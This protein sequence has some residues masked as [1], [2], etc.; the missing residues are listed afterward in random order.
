MWR[1]KETSATL[2][3]KETVDGTWFTETTDT[4]VLH[5]ERV[6]LLL[7]R[8]QSAR[9]E[10]NFKTVHCGC[11]LSS[12]MPLL[13]LSTM[14]LCEKGPDTVERMTSEYPFQKLYPKLRSWF[15]ASKR[16]LTQSSSSRLS[17]CNHSCED[18]NMFII[19]FFNILAIIWYPYDEGMRPMIPGLRGHMGR[20]W[21]GNTDLTQSAVL[22]LSWYAW[23][24][25]RWQ[26]PHLY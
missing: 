12:V 3:N 13:M 22:P 17:D 11:A 2:E 16:S 7:P 21:L 8:S 20:K 1:T 23:Q 24:E 26:T 15:W 4:S 18:K 14:Y 6:P 5:A 25:T 9:Y 19:E 10:A